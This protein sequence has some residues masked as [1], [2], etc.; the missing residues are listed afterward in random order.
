MDEI[1]ERFINNA[2][3]I[4]VSSD[5]KK[6][7]FIY[8]KLKES[9][10]IYSLKSYNENFVAKDKHLCKWIAKYLADSLNAGH[11]GKSN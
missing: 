5:N 1:K 2:F 7:F 6:K 9:Q 11:S 4:F 8:W 3:V 10:Q